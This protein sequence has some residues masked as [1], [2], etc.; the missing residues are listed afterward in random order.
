MA[1]WCGIL[2][3]VV[4]AISCA[5]IRRRK[6]VGVTG[7][8]L[9]SGL[10][11]IALLVRPGEEAEQVDLAETKVRPRIPRASTR[12]GYVSSKA[13]IDCHPEE[14]AS[15][16]SSFHRTMTQKVTPESMAAPAEEVVLSSRGRDFRFRPEGN[17]FLTETVDPEWDADH[18]YSGSIRYPPNEDAPYVRRQIVMS[19]GS[20]H[21]QTYWINGTN[22]NQLWR[23][24]WLYHI[25]L[26]RWMPT[27]DSFIMPPMN[28][29][30]VQSWHA[31][32]IPCHSVAGD[33]G[34]DPGGTVRTEVAE[35]GIAC[36]ACHGPGAAHVAMQKKLRD[37][38]EVP[39]ELDTRIINPARLSHKRSSE[40]C[41]Q[42][43]GLLDFTNREERGLQF[44]PGQ[45][46]SDVYPPM[47]F[48]DD[49][50]KTNPDLADSFWNDG[51]MRVA[52]RDFSA[53]RESAC[54]TK[55]QISCVSC[56]SMH[57]YETPDD[58][59]GPS[60]RT[61]TSCLQCHEDL[62]A[63]I[64]AHTHHLAGSSGSRCSNCH[65]PHTTL[66]LMKSI[67]SHRIDSPTSEMTVKHG[68]PNAC[69]L[70]HVDQSMAWID[71]HLVNWYGH[72]PV[73]KDLPDDVSPAVELLLSGDAVQRAVLVWNFCRDETRKASGD[74]WQQP[75]IAELLNDPYSVVRAMAWQSIKDDP[76]AIG[77][78]YDF[79]ASEDQRL[80]ARNTLIERWSESRRISGSQKRTAVEL[81]RLMQTPAGQRDDARL[82]R[83]I[84]RRNER[85]IIFAE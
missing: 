74:D 44:Y 83:L 56:H 79:L 58:Q 36:E 31:N 5:I 32:C 20:H 2:G 62:K 11:L 37:S 61:D 6:A 39:T 17:R 50:V 71:H 72:D 78:D 27:Q 7:F 77:I 15:W 18:V 66:G 63:D 45:K 53:L 9:T 42:C 10:F 76:A 35:L 52:G 64:S 51:T 55:G 34:V 43:H 81:K 29:R 3:F 69:V 84:H 49:D 4:L 33:G 1:F 8:L 12:D 46:L 28:L 41:G 85:P 65:M 21:Y 80:K 47:D 24:P 38:S 48:K 54:Y 67:R 40:V 13:C 25:E 59:L 75:L 68:R 82:Q 16:T 14:H 30:V 60:M 57:R 19:T 26:Q 23:L 73:T 22:G 70:C